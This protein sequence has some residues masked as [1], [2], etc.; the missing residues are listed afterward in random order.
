[1]KKTS[2]LAIYSLIRAGVRCLI[3]LFTMLVS[4]QEVGA[5][6][7]FECG[8]IVKQALTPEQHPAYYDRFG[9]EYTED[10]VSLSFYPNAQRLSCNSGYFALSFVGNWTDN[11]K[12]TA[13]QVFGDLSNLLM[14]SNPDD[15]PPINILLKKEVLE[16]SVAGLG[17]PFFEA[18]CGIVDSRILYHLNNAYEDNYALQFLGTIQ[19]NSGLSWHTVAD[20]NTTFAE[21]NVPN[22]K[23]DLYTV[24]LHEALHILGFLSRITPAGASLDNFYSRWDKYLFS[25]PENAALLIPVENEACCNYY[26][27]NATVFDNMPFDFANGCG[28]KIAFRDNAANNIAAVNIAD[29]TSF[30]GSNGMGFF[31]NK[32]SHLDYNCQAELGFSVPKAVIHP[33]IDY[34]EDRRFITDPEKNILC[35]IGYHLNDISN[36]EQDC[37]VFTNPDEYIVFLSEGGTISISVEGADGLLSNDVHSEGATV[38][39]DTEC[40]YMG[41]LVVNNMVAGSSISLTAATEGI[42]HF[43]YTVESCNDICRT[44]EVTIIV[45]QEPLSTHCDD[46]YCNIVCFGDFEEFNTTLTNN[47]FNQLNIPPFRF[48]ETANSPDVWQLDDNNILHIGR[49][50][51]CEIESI[52][53][54]LSEPI[55]PGCEVIVS[56][57]A[58]ATHNMY[59][60]NNPGIVPALQFTALNNYPCNDFPYFNCTPGIFNICG[61]TTAANMTP[62]VCGQAIDFQAI[63]SGQFPSAINVINFN[64]LAAQSFTWVNTTGQDITTLLITTNTTIGDYSEVG[65]IIYFLDNLIVTLQCEEQIDISAADQDEVCTDSYV[66]I[67]Y[68]V[69][70]QNADSPPTEPISVFLDAG[71]EGIAG[72]SVLPDG[73]F[74][75]NGQAEVVLTGASSCVTVT[76]A[77]YIGNN[78]ETGDHIN[79]PLEAFND[80]GYCIDGNGGGMDVVLEIKDCGY[81]PPELDCLDGINYFTVSPSDEGIISIES[82]GV[83]RPSYMA[84]S[85]EWTP[86]SH[87]F[88]S[89]TA[90]NPIYFNTDLVVPT[91]V[92]LTINNLYLYFAPDRRILVQ[93]GG[94][95]VLNNCTID[96]VCQMMWQGIQV[97]GPGN[98]IVP[99]NA[100]SGR[101]NLVGGEIRNAIIGAAAMNLAQLNTFAIAVFDWPADNDY[102]NT[103][104]LTMPILWTLPARNTAGGRIGTT[105][106]KFIDCF[107]GLNFSW[108]NQASYDVKTAQFL[109]NATNLWF[110][111]TTL[112]SRPEAGV[113]ALWINRLSAVGCTFHDLKY[114]IRTNDANFAQATNNTFNRNTIGISARQILSLVAQG[115]NIKGNQFENCQLAVQA[116]GIDFNKMSDNTVNLLGNSQ[117]AYTGENLSLGFYL[118]GSNSIVK[119]NFIHRT[120][121]GM[122]F[123]QSDVEG[124]LVAGN[125]VNNSEEALLIEGNNQSAQFKCNHL[126]DYNDCGL[127]LRAFNGFNGVLPQQGEC[128]DPAVPIQQPAANSFVATLDMGAVDIRLSPNTAT[129]EYHDVGATTL[130]VDDNSA[131]GNFEPENCAY[132][133]LNTYCSQYGFTSLDDVDEYIGIGAMQDRILA[134]KILLLV[135]QDS[136]YVAAL[137][138]LHQYNNTL[139]AKRRLVPHKI[140][141]DST[142]MARNILEQIALDGEENLRY[143]QLYGLL[144]DLKESH[145][146]IHDISPAEQSLLTDVANSSTKTGYKAQAIL[147]LAR[148]IEFPVVLPALSN[149]TG[150]WHTVFK[151]DTNGK[152]STLY[153]NPTQSTISFEHQLIT[154]QRGKLIIYDLLGKQISQHTFVGSGQQELSIAHLSAGMYLYT[155]QVDDLIIQKAKLV[156]IP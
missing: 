115:T 104:S 151:T 63:P 130:T 149:G 42:Y 6:N 119:N 85:A 140:G 49:C 59:S 131:I 103:S 108:N 66:Y 26:G 35:T 55:H 154:G 60:G 25:V 78:F 101:L 110:P 109:K 122:V 37:E 75:G 90:N 86:L 33:N 1:M 120:D 17:T 73:D 112:S 45:K 124:T 105:D 71:I 15:M 97:E 83:S 39:F 84:N 21:P 58:I 117:T 94:S 36:C 50:P 147:Y 111:F 139:L 144:I 57:N 99:T 98:N 20:D 100:N 114:G 8:I 77:L 62:D 41:D 134:K 145:R 106:T 128:N 82:F 141:M 113:S 72:V 96:G 129:L 14:A 88:I 48:T 143:K 13:C 125:L 46:P 28:L 142:A 47:Y 107:Q 43:C 95:L 12:N 54:P 44:E 3:V 135:T 127:E 19:I 74:N 61:G 155:I 56:Y 23:L 16:S 32:L 67:P 121:F 80:G 68:E 51:T 138:L 156:L 7:S 2:F 31:L 27:F 76:L 123:N 132:Q 118:R 133:D 79:I 18:N 146:S 89:Q 5:Q 69:C 30:G 10:E 52:A 150:N 29:Y 53:V 34:G 93:P 40:G 11:E 116:D 152:V 148:G 9:N 81:A 92:A 24:M 22:T 70:L 4:W 126:L 64:N 136:N 65:H 38:S 137:G 91:G 102:S 87:P 153:P